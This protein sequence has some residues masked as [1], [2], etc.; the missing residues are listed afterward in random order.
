MRYSIITGLIVLLLITSSAIH[1]PGKTEKKL[2][3][4]KWV[5]GEIRFVEN[6]QLEYYKRGSNRNTI[7]F[8]D[9]YVIF[10]KDFSGEYSNGKEINPVKWK[11]ANGR[12]NAIEYTIQ[13]YIPLTIYWENVR[14]TADAISY[15]EYY[16]KEDGVSVMAI[17]TRKVSW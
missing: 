14:I 3:D 5:F 12:K 10:R 2:C 11:F 17:A 13:K 15:T 7:A 8:P 6:N 16:T 9:D 1:T 4:K